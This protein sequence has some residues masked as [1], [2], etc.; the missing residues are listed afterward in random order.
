[1]IAYLKG[2]VIHVGDNNVL[3]L[4]NGGLGYEITCSSAA[5]SRLVMAK[6][7]EVY[8]YLAVREDGVFLYGFDSYAEKN[9]FLK[10]ITVSGVGPKM[11]I[12]VLSGM[13]LNDL[14]FAIAASDIKSLSKIKGLGKKTAERIV[15]ELREAIGEVGESS[16]AKGATPISKLSNDGEDAIIALMG[17]GY[18][19]TQASSSVQAAIEAGV[20]GLENIIREALKRFA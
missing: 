6:G 20:K 10:L 5:F 17:L 8:T 18:T 1:M 2:N 3:V 7:G 19:R 15:L 13:S 12:T 16:A 4:E 11:G 9:M 14:A